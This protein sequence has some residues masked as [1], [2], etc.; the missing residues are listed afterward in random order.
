MSTTLSDRQYIQR[1]QALERANQVY[2][3]RAKLKQRIAGGEISA[4]QLI[5]DP[6]PEAQSWPVAELLA[7]QRRWG[8]RRARKLLGFAM[9]GE[10]KALGTLTQR[11]RVKL[12]GLLERGR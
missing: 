11:Q 7:C 8:A 2:R 3:D 5:L 1:L 4:A 6:P 9:I 10:R 12:A